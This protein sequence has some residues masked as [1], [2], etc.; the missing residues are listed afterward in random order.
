M[1][2]RAVGVTFLLAWL[3]VSVAAAHVTILP[4]TVA[5]GSFLSFTVRVPSER[6]VPTVG[7]RIEFPPELT[8]SR[9][10][11]KP[12][13]KR[14]VEKDQAGRI[15][16]AGWQ[17][18][19]IGSDEYE[20]FVFLGRTP[21]TATRLVF[22]TFQTYQD[23]ETVGWTG[24]EDSDNPAPVVVVTDEIA[25]PAAPDEGEHTTDP[26]GTIAANTA[27]TAVSTVGPTT[28]P[29]PTEEQGHQGATITAATTV[30]DPS[31]IDFGPNLGQPAAAGSDLGLLAGLT[32]L[33]LAAIAL[34]LAGIALFKPSS[35]P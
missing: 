23:D 32:A 29:A 35:R 22:R 15:V 5:A 4:G 28:V 26:T 33:V 19:T 25:T 17:G 34:A 10:Q 16:A 7:V 12:G 27:A 9:F 24:A 3:L 18:G 2:R 13:W 21:P 14:T 8:V 31:M 1:N 11:P 30:A 6:E 20:E